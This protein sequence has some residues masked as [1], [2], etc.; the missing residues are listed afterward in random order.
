MTVPVAQSV[1][2]LGN[3]RFTVLVSGVIDLRE[4]HCSM[5]AMR[6]HVLF[7]QERVEDRKRVAWSDESRFRLLNADGRLRILR[8][9]HEAMDPACQVG[10]VQEHGGSIMARGVFSWHCL[11]CLMR[12]TTS[13]NAIWS[14][15]LLGDHLHPLML[16]CYPPGNGVFQQENFTS[17]KSQF[18]TGWLVENSSDFSVINWPPGSPDLNPIEHLWDV[19]GQG[20]KGCQ[21]APTNL[22][23]LW[24]TL[25]NIWLVITVERFQK[26]FQS[27]PRRVAVIIKVRG[28]PT[29]Y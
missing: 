15:V 6:L 7:G 22:T 13:R 14:V 4:Y 25:A 24:T 8:Q 10:I 18:A 27:M 17:H 19:S 12:L 20:V 2:A 29:R 3:N 1:N 28:G 21:T 11:R 16:F 23:E 26:L 9:A 5:L